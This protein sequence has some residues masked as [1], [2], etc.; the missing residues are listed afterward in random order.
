MV[1]AVDNAEQAHAH[2]D[3]PASKTARARGLAKRVQEAECLLVSPTNKLDP[4]GR[5]YTNRPQQPHVTDKEQRCQAK[6]WRMK[7]TEPDDAKPKAENE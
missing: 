5:A 7:Q 1:K 4:Q 6:Q 3:D 2:G